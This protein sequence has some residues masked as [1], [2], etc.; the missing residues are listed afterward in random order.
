MNDSQLTLLCRTTAQWLDHIA[1]EI[2]RREHEKALE[3][4]FQAGHIPINQPCVVVWYEKNEDL[5]RQPRATP[6]PAARHPR[7]PASLKAQRRPASS[8][9]SQRKS[10]P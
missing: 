3:A 7:R 9:K 6:E 2:D 5:L 10:R 4:A 8:G 1:C